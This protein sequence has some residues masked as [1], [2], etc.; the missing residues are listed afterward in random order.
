MKMEGINLN[1]VSFRWS[2]DRLLITTSHGQNMLAGQQVAQLLDFLQS[3]Q[4]EIYAGEQGQGLP[5][6]ATNETRYA[7]STVSQ[8]VPQLKEGT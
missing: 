1:G 4:Q 6:W 2:E 8:Q 3:H 7:A 5:E